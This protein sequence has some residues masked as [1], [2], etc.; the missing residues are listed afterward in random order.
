MTDLISP[1]R[2]P[3]N[4]LLEDR[5]TNIDIVVFA[6]AVLLVGLIGAVSGVS[7]IF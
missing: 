1:R 2:R 3:W 5:F 4:G 7:L 6:A